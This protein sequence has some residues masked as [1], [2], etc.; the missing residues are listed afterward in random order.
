MFKTIVTEVYLPRYIQAATSPKDLVILVD[1]SGSMTGERMVIARQT[2]E[3]I[4]ATLSD[5][6]FFN[7]LKVRWAYAPHLQSLPVVEDSQS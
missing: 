7:V 4:L 3:S 6:D 2:V 1:T 5:D